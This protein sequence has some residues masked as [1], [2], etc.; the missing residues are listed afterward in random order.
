MMTKGN[1][2]S[3][4]DSEQPS[5]PEQS[6][7]RSQL[8]SKLL[9]GFKS[10]YL[11]A[12]RLSTLSQLLLDDDTEKLFHRIGYGLMLS[13]ALVVSAVTTLDI[14]WI[15]SWEWESQTFFLHLRGVVTPPQDII[16]LEMDEASL[17]Q[18]QFYDAD[19]ESYPF[20]APIAQ[21][22]WQRTAYGVAID[23]LMQAGA[24]TVAIDLIFD[25]KSTWGEGDDD[26]LGHVLQRYPGQVVLASSFDDADQNTGTLLRLILPLP[27]FTEA[28][29]VPGYIDYPLE[30]NDRIH[31]FSQ[32]LLEG[33]S[34][35]PVVQTYLDR[36]PS[37]LLQ[38]FDQ[39]TFR[40]ARM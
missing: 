23:R 29:A 1:S 26:F 13:G 6:S 10:T 25:S 20:L 35:D 34:A 21:W 9:S 15:K 12:L 30:A 2:T 18:Q 36:L 4:R 16:I 32:L 11:G 17:G 5:R 40:A 37:S 14:R 3:S 38:S 31:Q 39:Q 19:P 8:G 27:E 7:E 22:P 24:R 33:M 28:G